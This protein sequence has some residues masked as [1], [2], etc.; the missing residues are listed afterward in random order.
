MPTLARTFY[1][2]CRP[3]LEVFV[4][5]TCKVMLVVFIKEYDDNDGGGETTATVPGD[6]DDDRY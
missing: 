3:G 5:Y 1:V 6:G 4:R 2:G